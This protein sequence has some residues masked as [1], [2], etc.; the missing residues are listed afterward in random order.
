MKKT[1]LFLL[2]TQISLA[3]ILSTASL[4]RR[5]FD[6]GELIVKFKN[7]VK[8]N[9]YYAKSK[10]AESYFNMGQ[11]GE[12]KDNSTE[13]QQNIN[14]VSNVFTSNYLTIS[15]I[16]VLKNTSSKIAI[17]LANNENIRGLQ[18][19]LNIPEGFTFDMDNVVETSTLNN[20]TTSI[21]SLG[22]NNYRFIIYTISNEYIVS[23]DNTILRLPIFIENTIDPGQYTFEFSN[24]VLSSEA[25]QN[26]SSEA[27]KIGYIN[28]IEDTIA[29]VITLL[30]DASVTVEVASTYNDTGATASDNYDGDITE[31]I[32]TVSNVD[33]DTVGTYT[34][35]YNV[36]DTSSNSAEEV[37]RTVNVASSLS[38]EDDPINDLNISPNPTQNYWKIS[39]S[40]NL[41]SIELFDVVGRKIFS[42][43]T[44]SK[45]F[46]INGSSLS[47]GVYFLI[48]NKKNIRRLIKN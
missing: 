4:N 11:L 19:D 45:N 7:N 42:V 40:V 8:D 17:N 38:I 5:N 39:S 27:Q 44:T 24:V 2:F 20:F 37:T 43:N 10:K 41:E 33:T 22:N 48:L 3:Q 28:V 26:I 47:N 35:T 13:K 25:N 18:Y 23:G 9:V 15:D 12:I 21:S 6:P 46:K 32:V 34:I 29:P 14:I 16:N 30:G 31:S 36:K 1:I